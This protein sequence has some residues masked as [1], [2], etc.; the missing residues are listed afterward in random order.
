M[1][2][3]TASSGFSRRAARPLFSVLAVLALLA[4]VAACDGVGS[5]F[6][7]TV[8]TVTVS[9]ADDAA[10]IVDRTITVNAFVTDNFGTAVPG[11]TVRWSVS[12]GTLASETS[13]AASDGEDR[14]TATVAWTLGTT[15]DEQQITARVEGAEGVTSTTTLSVSA[16]PVG[17]IEAM[18]EQDTLQVNRA[19]VLRITRLEDTFGNV[20]PPSD[21]ARYGLSFFSLDTLVAEITDPPAGTEGAEDETRGVRGVGEG[22]ALIGVI[23]AAPPPRGRGFKVADGA[24]ADTL[25]LSVV[26]FLSGGPFPATTI[27]TGVGFSC[28]IDT[29]GA[30]Y[31]WGANATGQ[32][33]VGDFTP[34]LV[35]ERI[36]GLP[37]PVASVS[38]G[39]I[40]AC[41]LLESD[42]VFCWGSGQSGRLGN[43][44]DEGLF[45]APESVELPQG[46]GNIVDIRAGESATCIRTDDGGAYC[47]GFDGGGT[48]GNG[49]PP[50]PTEEDLLDI[51]IT[52]PVRVNAPPGVRFAS[53][54]SIALHTCAVAEDGAAYCWGQNAPQFRLGN[55]FTTDFN[56]PEPARVQ[57][58][59][60]NFRSV[61]AHSLASSGLDVNGQ[62]Y[63]WGEP[64]I[65]EPSASGLTEQVFQA[66]P[67]PTVESFV[68]LAGGGGD[69]ACAL[70]S[71]AAASCWGDNL[72]GQLGTGDTTDT[73]TPVPVQT[74]L[75]FASIDVSSFF[76]TCAV[77]EGGGEAYCWGDNQFGQAGTGGTQLAIFTPTRVETESEDAPRPALLRT[78]VAAHRRA[79]C[80]AIPDRLR[81]T[82][83]VCGPL[84]LRGLR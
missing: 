29:E 20:I 51:S 13:T 46:V 83:S 49:A 22:E 61:V 80:A 84:R 63:G 36:V 47:W 19:T 35:P 21:Y 33:G 74:D 57:P 81:R 9:F 72:R 27:S 53:L 52:T 65:P 11:A 6:E 15:A 55:G 10:L 48:V 77:V 41:A 59:N 14:G 70:T 23:A 38:A 75:R 7:G 82:T 68:T 45:P 69:H 8:E 5:D 26:S 79:W 73:V 16:G 30:A 78:S 37:G 4:A 66:T 42:Q 12:E 3:D 62:L 34:R 60:I 40:H 24:A 39:F 50:M 28:G 18:L 58:T 2:L 56:S 64:S 17:D 25:M 32:L 76:Q 54:G 67:V 1:L 44:T 71:T 43:G 31:C